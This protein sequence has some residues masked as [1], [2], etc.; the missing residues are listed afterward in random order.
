MSSAFGRYFFFFNGLAGLDFVGEGLLRFFGKY[1][2]CGLGKLQHTRAFI[3]YTIK[4]SEVLL[5]PS[6]VFITLTQQPN[7]K[8][9]RTVP[10]NQEQISNTEPNGPINGKDILPRPSEIMCIS[11]ANDHVRGA[12][13]LTHKV[14]L[15]CLHSVPATQSRSIEAILPTTQS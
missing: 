4:R 8:T 3:K 7:S 2:A 13:S 9:W 15:T 12:N 5:N 1:L 6:P 14:L 10:Y 11:D